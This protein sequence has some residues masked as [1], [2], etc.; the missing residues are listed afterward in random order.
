MPIPKMIKTAPARNHGNSSWYLLRKIAR[1][2]PEIFDGIKAGKYDSVADAARAA[3]VLPDI[4][5]DDKPLDDLTSAWLKADT[6]TRGIFMWLLEDDEFVNAQKP[7]P[8]HW[9]AEQEIPELE[10]LLS[11]LGTIGAVAD[12]IGVSVRTVRRW[13]SGG[14]KPPKAKMAALM[15]QAEINGFE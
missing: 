2:K 8:W 15:D 4:H 10:F 1:E 14:A 3:G 5:S 13:R 12:N 9:K 11:K 7:K 6:E